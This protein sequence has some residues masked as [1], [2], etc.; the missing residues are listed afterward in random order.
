[1]AE[2]KN[3]HQFRIP[4]QTAQKEY[5][6]RLKGPDRSLTKFA[7]ACDLSTAT[8]SRIINGKNAK[9]VPIV[10]LQKIYAGRDPNCGVTEDEFFEAAGYITDERLHEMNRRRHDRQLQRM[11][12]R[13][14]RRKDMRTIIREEL[15][16]RGVAVQIAGVPKQL[17]ENDSLLFLPYRAMDMAMDVMFSGQQKQ[18]GFVINASIADSDDDDRDA[19][20]YIRRCI[21]SWASLFLEDAWAPE[22]MKN[23]RITF[24]FADEGYYKAFIA[25]LKTAP[26][27]S[28]MTAL[29]VDVTNRSVVSE[30]SITRNAIESLF[31]LPKITLGF[32]DDDHDDSS[33]NWTDHD[34]TD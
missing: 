34:T 15:F 26:I 29:L 17:E 28:E 9:A 14:R 2:E 12:E 5:I 3:Y 10:T 19:R 22:E 24:A 31:D 27:N 4:N 1:M 20:Y 8:L 18:W 7:T 30:V 13:D 16:D 25:A 21:D 6:M 32:D 11:R 33:G 23:N